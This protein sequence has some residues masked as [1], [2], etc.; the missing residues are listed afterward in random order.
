[1]LAEPDLGEFIIHAFI[2]RKL[3]MSSNAPQPAKEERSKVPRSLMIDL[4]LSAAI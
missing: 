4:T 1:M 3:A 2:L